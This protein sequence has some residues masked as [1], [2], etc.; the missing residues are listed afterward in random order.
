MPHDFSRQKSE[1]VTGMAEVALG[2]GENLDGRD[3][4]HEY[5]IWED[6]VLIMMVKVAIAYQILS[7]SVPPGCPHR[8]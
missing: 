3:R 4:E 1:L 7:A 6:L 5:R 2:E 8:G